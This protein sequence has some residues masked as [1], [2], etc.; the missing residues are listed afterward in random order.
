[1]GETVP[2][3]GNARHLL[4]APEGRF[5]R[6]TI[7]TGRA[8]KLEFGMKL[9][10]RSLRLHFR[11]SHGANEEKHDFDS[12]K[13]HRDKA[14]TNSQP[15]TR[16]LESKPRGGV[17]GQHHCPHT[18]V[19]GFSGAFGVIRSGRFQRSTWGVAGFG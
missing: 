7:G 8:E 11:S 9:G 5:A 19:Y 10:E 2:E 16:A 4:S 14:H 15:T 1:M 18:R 17:W 3:L 12:P 13:R 6:D